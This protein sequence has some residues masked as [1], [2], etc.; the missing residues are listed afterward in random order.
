V[1]AAVLDAAPPGTVLFA[2]DLRIARVHR[3]VK[4][5]GGRRDAGA[6]FAVPTVLE[7]PRP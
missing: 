7:P 4:R 6:R 1:L 3:A 5:I 2:P